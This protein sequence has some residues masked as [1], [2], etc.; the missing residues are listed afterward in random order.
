MPNSATCLVNPWV[1]PAASVSQDPR[2]PCSSPARTCLGSCASASSSTEMRSAVVLEPALPRRS[3]AAT[4]PFGVAHIAQP[5]VTSVTLLPGPG[6][7]FRVRMRGPQ[8]RVQIHR[9]QSRLSWRSLPDPGTGGARADRIAVSARSAP[10]ASRSISSIPSDPRPPHRTPPAAPAP[11]RCRRR[12]PRPAPPQALD[13][14]R[15]CPDHAPPAAAATAPTPPTTSAPGSTPA[16]SAPAGRGDQRSATAVTDNHGSHWI[17]FTC[18]G[19]S[20]EF[21]YDLRQAIVSL[22]GQALR[23]IT[24]RLYPHESSRWQ[25]VTTSRSVPFP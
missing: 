7:P 11:P 1:A 5:R 20:R 8:G 13:P 6:R 23:H 14:A 3:R 9:H 18:R 22:T 17:S 12:S 21:D 2:L 25:G 4:V 24:C 19:R 15:S 10:A 16:R